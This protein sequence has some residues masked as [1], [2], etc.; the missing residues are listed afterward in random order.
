MSAYVVGSLHHGSRCSLSSA[1]RIL[2]E[3]TVVRKWLLNRTQPR[4]CDGTQPRV[5]NKKPGPSFLLIV[6]SPLLLSLLLFPSL[7]LSLPLISLE[8]G[9]K[10]HMCSISLCRGSIGE[11]GGNDRPTDRQELR[12]SVQTNPV[13]MHV[14][15]L[16]S[17]PST[18]RAAIETQPLL[19]RDLEAEAPS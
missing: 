17:K 9:E 4:C 14:S 11:N 13:N 10:V 12:L 5:K 15:E 8:L 19:H 3:H 16:G 18:S 6:F 2:V 1:V 7:S